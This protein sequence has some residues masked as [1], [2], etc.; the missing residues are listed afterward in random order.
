MI[1]E[2][3]MKRTLILPTLALVS[4]FTMGAGNGA[5]EGEEKDRELRRWNV[6]APHTEINF[7]VKHFFT[8]VTGTFRDFEIEF[9]FDA[10]APE[11]SSVKVSID[12]ASID[13][14]NERRDNHLR[15]GDFFDAERFPRMTFESTSVRK[16]GSNQLVATGDLTI[17]ETTREVE[18]AIEILG[19]RDLP[20]EMQEMMGGITRVAGFEASSTID[21]RA[22]EVGV[23][24][25]A[26][27]VIV[28]GEVE[29]SIALEANH[30]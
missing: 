17:K 27:T 23:A 5:P 9:M 6:D 18:L 1:K 24:N 20:P 11:N 10:E 7:S 25:W 2:R 8:P 13:T 16:E 3:T 15:S 26:Q 4:L 12:V 21:R 28:G 14:K 19:V 30:Q 22:F 29:I